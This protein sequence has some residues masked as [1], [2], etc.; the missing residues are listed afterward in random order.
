MA[1]PRID[2]LDDNL[3]LAVGQ[4]PGTIID[5]TQKEIE[6]LGRTIIQKTNATISAATKSIIPN[7]PKMIENLTK[8]INEGKSGEQF[9]KSIKRFEMIIDV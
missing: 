1:L 9:A 2:P 5:T 3:D 6:E 7:I 4:L 8:E